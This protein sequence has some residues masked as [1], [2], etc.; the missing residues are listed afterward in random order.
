MEW[1]GYV[2][3][4]TPASEGHAAGVYG[5]C[6]TFWQGKEPGMGQGKKVQVNQ[7]G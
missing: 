7:T 1:L 6:C 2:R 3:L 4:V 5:A